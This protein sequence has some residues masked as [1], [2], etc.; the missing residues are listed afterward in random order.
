MVNASYLLITY[1]VP[2]FKQ[3]SLSIS[4]CYLVYCHFMNVNRF[5]GQAKSFPGN[6]PLSPKFHEVLIIGTKQIYKTQTLQPLDYS[7]FEGAV[8]QW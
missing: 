4:G 3:S 2:N 6:F 1:P 5:Q 7:D 8:A